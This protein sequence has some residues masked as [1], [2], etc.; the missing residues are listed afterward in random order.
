MECE[1]FGNVGEAH[2]PGCGS[3]QVFSLVVEKIAVSTTHHLVC[4][5]CGYR[6]AISRRTAL[7]YMPHDKSIWQNHMILLSWLF[8]F[9]SIVAVAIVAVIR[10]K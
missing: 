10:G 9:L 7:K 3:D 4:N 1:T 6:T 2:C 8:L 5:Q